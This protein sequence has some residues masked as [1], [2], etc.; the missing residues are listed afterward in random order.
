MRILKSQISDSQWSVMTALWL[1]D[2]AHQVNIDIFLFYLYLFFWF[3]CSYFI[4]LIHVILMMLHYV[5]FSIVYLTLLYWIWFCLLFSILFNSAF[6]FLFL[7]LGYVAPEILEG[8]KYGKK[9]F[10]LHRFIEGRLL[11]CCHFTFCT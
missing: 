8:R 5:I 9:C 11:D 3:I 2:A 1:R 4:K 7:F 10:L 6:C